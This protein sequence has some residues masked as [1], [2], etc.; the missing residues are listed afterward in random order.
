[1]QLNEEEIISV[2]Y[3]VIESLQNKN[4]NINKVSNSLVTN[5]KKDTLKQIST[6]T[7]QIKI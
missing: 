5:G 1:M 2:T 4:I 3:S 7:F 6:I